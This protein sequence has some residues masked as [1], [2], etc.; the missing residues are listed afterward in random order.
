VGGGKEDARERR[1]DWV[2]RSREG[3]KRLGY[4]RDEE[5]DEKREGREGDV[6]KEHMIFPY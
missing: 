1:S 4:A 2:G 6:R 3:R 5:R